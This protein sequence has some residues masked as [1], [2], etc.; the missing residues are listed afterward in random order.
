MHDTEI[1][2]DNISALCRKMIKK[3]LRMYIEAKTDY[4]RGTDSYFP[5]TYYYKKRYK[6]HTGEGEFK[7]YAII[8]IIIITDPFSGPSICICY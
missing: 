6:F 1:K 7:L 2:P 3:Y 4:K 8:V 5:I